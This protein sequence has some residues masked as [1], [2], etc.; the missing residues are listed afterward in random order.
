MKKDFLY[1]KIKSLI[2]ISPTKL[3]LKKIKDAL[4]LIQ[5][6]DLGEYRH[7]FSRLNIIFITNKN[8][9]TNEFFMPEKIWFA[10][11]SLIKNNDVNWLASLIIHEAFHSTQF[12][13]GK[14]ISPLGER[15]EKP[16]IELQE[17]FLE[18]LEGKKA[19][20]EMKY[21]IQKRYWE[22]TED[23]RKGFSYFR[24]LL[25]LFQNKKIKLKQVIAS[26]K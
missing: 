26:K 19:R 10:N 25:D 14:Y 21:L 5:K 20:K 15:L 24:N 7:L 17:K 9:Y 11:K 22:K 6:T 13:N 18:K 1:L 3:F 12:K 23:D 2:I 8:G 4:G 16:A